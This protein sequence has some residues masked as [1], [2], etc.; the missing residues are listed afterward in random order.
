MSKLQALMIWA[1]LASIAFAI[2]G[3]H[4]VSALLAVFGVLVLLLDSLHEK[5]GTP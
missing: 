5:E 1:G 3:D 4:A 2:N